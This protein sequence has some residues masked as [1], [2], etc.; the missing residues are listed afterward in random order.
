MTDANGDWSGE[1]ELTVPGTGFITATAT[2]LEQG[3]SEFSE[4]MS[5]IPDDLFEDGYEAILPP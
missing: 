4:C 2:Q 3:T 1:V 5:T